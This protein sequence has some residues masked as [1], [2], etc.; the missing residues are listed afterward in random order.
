MRKRIA[1]AAIA[2]AVAVVVA[3]YVLSH[4]KEGSVEW[5]KKEFRRAAS[6]MKPGPWAKRLAG[7]YQKVTRRQAP[8]IGDWYEEKEK[9]VS[10]YTALVNMG[11]LERRRFGLTNRHGSEIQ[12]AV[13]RAWGGKKRAAEAFVWSLQTRDAI[14][15]MA[16]RTM[17]PRVEEIVRKTDVP[18][19]GK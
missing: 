12:S 3:A 18:E 5:H 19:N 7:T 4:P 8:W 9:Y 1:I 14:V 17:M 11:Y 13:E 2:V 16:P 10:S 6:R 15:V